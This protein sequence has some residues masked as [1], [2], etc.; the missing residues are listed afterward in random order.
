MQLELFGGPA[1]DAITSE[2]YPT[3]YRIERNGS[4]TVTAVVPGVGRLTAHHKFLWEATC[5]VREQIA[6]ALESAPS[7]M[8]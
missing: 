4:F 7:T 3:T 8:F 6:K 2:E 5:L 1:A